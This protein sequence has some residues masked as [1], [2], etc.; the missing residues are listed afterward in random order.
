[1]SYPDELARWVS[2]FAERLGLSKEVAYSMAGKALIS[3]NK[4]VTNCFPDFLG[5]Y[6]RADPKTRTLEMI[7]C[8]TARWAMSQILVVESSEDLI[9]FIIRLNLAIDAKEFPILGMYVQERRKVQN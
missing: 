4:C 5:P 9:D 8:K 7:V 1:M 6:L 2:L 3:G